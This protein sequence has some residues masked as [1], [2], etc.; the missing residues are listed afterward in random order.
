VTPLAAQERDE[1]VKF[2]KE[3]PQGSIGLIIYYILT[4]VIG[5][6]FLPKLVRN[7]GSQGLVAF[8]RGHKKYLHADASDENIKT[9]AQI[10]TSFFRNSKDYPTTCIAK[11]LSVDDR[12]EIL[13]LGRAGDGDSIME[14]LKRKFGVHVF[15]SID[16][17]F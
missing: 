11:G 10:E 12:I 13:K 1:F 8:A 5:L 17:N 14:Y 15:T 6:Q 4:I 7:V 16:R 3:A 2:C 9:Y